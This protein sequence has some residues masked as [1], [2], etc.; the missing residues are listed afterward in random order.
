MNV[1][2]SV[3]ASGGVCKT[4]WPKKTIKLLN[5]GDFEKKIA[6]RSYLPASLFSAD[7]T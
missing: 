5:A 4:P 7:L 1:G 2:G 6:F 3:L